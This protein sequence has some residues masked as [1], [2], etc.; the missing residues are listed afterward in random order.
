M[1]RQSYVPDRGDVVWISFSKQEG[2][3]QRGRRPAFV[4]SSKLYNERSDL[5]L[6]CPITSQEK[7]YAFEVPIRIEKIRG[8]IL[9]DQLRS[10]D[11][12][13]RR[14]TFSVKAGDD[15]TEDVQHKLLLLITG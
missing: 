12:R 6:M 5:A 9:T 15:V 13:A 1:V 2:H 3:E 10:I 4:V 7:T 11:W 8:V 14:V